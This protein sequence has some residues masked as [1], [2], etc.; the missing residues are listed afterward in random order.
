MI[1]KPDGSVDEGKTTTRRRELRSA[2]VILTV[3]AANDEMFDGPKRQ[4]MI[5]TESAQNIHVDDGDM[6]EITAGKGAN[7]RGWARI[8]EAD[9][10][11]V[12]ILGPSTLRLI[13]ASPGELAEVR[14]VRRAPQ[15]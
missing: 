10:N 4:F 3:Q 11:G 5:S 12:V 1:L 2:R 7:I 6:I 13:Q 15:V 9:G 8:S 14:V